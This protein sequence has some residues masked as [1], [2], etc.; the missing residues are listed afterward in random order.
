M[1]RPPGARSSRPKAVRKLVLSILGCASR[2]VSRNFAPADDL[3]ERRELSGERAHPGLKRAPFRARPRRLESCRELAQP[4]RPD[5][6]ARALALG[7]RAR[8]SLQGGFW[9]GGAQLLEQSRGAH[10]EG[11]QD[12]AHERRIAP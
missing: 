9:Q 12:L 2:L 8:L 7:I 6:V 4:W 10:L 5:V 3:P 11:R 1:S